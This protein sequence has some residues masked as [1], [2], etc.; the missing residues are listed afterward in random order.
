[1]ICEKCKEAGNKSTISL[2]RSTSTLM[3]WD[4]G[5]FDEEGRWHT[6]PDPN[7]S[8]QEYICSNGHRWEEKVR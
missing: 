4:P 7:S 5:Y 2:G 3:S 6:I 8:F 1:M